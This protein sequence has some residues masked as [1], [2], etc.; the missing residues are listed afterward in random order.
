MVFLDVLVAGSFVYECNN[1][2]FLFKNHHFQLLAVWKVEAIRAIC[3]IMKQFTANNIKYHKDVN[4]YCA[5]NVSIYNSLY[6]ILVLFGCHTKNLY[7]WLR[8]RKQE[9]L[10]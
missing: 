8:G 3:V 4:I 10:R 2:T 1:S 6:L 5:T 9:I 7:V